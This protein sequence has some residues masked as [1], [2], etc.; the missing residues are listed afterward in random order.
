MRLDRLEV[1]PY[2][3][4]FRE[5]YRTARG[6]LRERELLLVRIRAEGLE[7]I[8]ETAALSL[9]GGHPLARIASDLERVCWPALLES[10]FDPAR[11]WSAVARCR[12]RGIS[13]E[14]IAALDI[15]LHDLAAKSQGV[16]VWRL[17]GADSAGPVPCNATLP[18]ANPTRF[19]ALL[20]R[21]S[22]EGFRTFKLKV[23]LP[24]DIAQ[25]AAA[26]SMLGSDARIRIDAN[27]AW[28]VD[29]AAE[30]LRLMARETI[31]LA[32][33]PVSG[34]QPMADLRRRT[35]IPLAA[36]ESIVGARDAREARERGACSLAAVKLA[37]AGGI[38][39]AL[40]IAGE[41]PVYLSSAL[42]GPVGIAAAAHTAQALPRRSAAIDL[43]HGLATERLFSESIGSGAVLA[44]SELRVSEEPGLGVEIDENAL[45]SR[46]LG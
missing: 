26:R 39:A 14:A 43:A 28:V 8:G 31:E 24:G 33:E 21:W 41:I 37:K 9:R 29:E 30:R 1:V 45:A 38:A 13:A 42:E 34:L 17:L 44:G 20:E 27:G 18:A 12:G 36:D 2:S 25:V 32:E 35:R 4:P 10:P 11:I 3:L 46:R 6:E 15:A 16:P 22:A 7:G 40:E 5:P 19:R 23:G